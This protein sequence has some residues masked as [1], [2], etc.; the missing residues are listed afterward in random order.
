MLKCQLADKGR[1]W[2]TQAAKAYCDCVLVFNCCD[3][4]SHL[5]LKSYLNTNDL[6][7]LHHSALHLFPSV[8]QMGQSCSLKTQHLWALTQPKRQVCI[9]PIQVVPKLL[10]AK[11]MTCRACCEWTHC[12]S[13]VFR[14]FVFTHYNS[15][16]INFFKSRAKLPLTPAK[17]G[18]LWL[19]KV[20]WCVFIYAA[21]ACW[22]WLACLLAQETEQPCE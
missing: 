22:P 11:L 8:F 13:T 15:L 16:L 10:T 6:Q 3:M 9:L 21:A 17:T 2:F 14:E 1:F 12:R 7:I 18:I 20:I 5:T 4:A 19:S